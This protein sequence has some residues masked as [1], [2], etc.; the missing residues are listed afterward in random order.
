MIV[1]GSIKL[2]NAPSI[3]PN[4]LDYYEEGK[5]TPTIRGYTTA[6]VGTY[7]SSLVFGSFVRIGNV[8]TINFRVAWTAHTGN[9]N[10]VITGIPYMPTTGGQYPSYNQ[11]AGAIPLSISNYSGGVFMHSD[12]VVHCNN[13]GGWN[14]VGL[15]AS[16]DIICCAS[17]ITG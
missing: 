12:G 4:T 13:N 17:F 16:G 5:F 6:G 15:M 3:D 1:T 14:A 8:C 10:L 9:G 2:L 7:T 11:V